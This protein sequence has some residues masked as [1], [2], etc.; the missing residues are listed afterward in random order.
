MVQKTL[1][2]AFR[3]RKKLQKCGYS[4]LRQMGALVFEP[5]LPLSKTQDSSDITSIILI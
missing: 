5:L 3:A 1:N 2:G 4:G